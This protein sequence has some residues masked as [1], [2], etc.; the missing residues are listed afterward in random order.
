[1]QHYNANAV[2]KT[3]QWHKLLISL[4]T[5]YAQIRIATEGCFFNFSIPRPVLCEHSSQYYQLS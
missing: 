5:S 4:K 3:A 1:M 2:D